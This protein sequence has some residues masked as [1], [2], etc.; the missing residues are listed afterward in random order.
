MSNQI[1]TIII[2]AFSSAITL[3]VILIYST[4]KEKNYKLLHNS[5]YKK[6]ILKSRYRYT[7]LEHTSEEFNPEWIKDTEV[8]HE[9][10]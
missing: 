10:D 5:K 8:W 6:F 4:F 2:S 7:N 3:I 9:W 1:D